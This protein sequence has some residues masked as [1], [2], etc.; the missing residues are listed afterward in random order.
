MG[1]DCS[2]NAWHGAYS[3]FHRWRCEI[4]KAAGYPALELMEGFF[5]S[6][7]WVPSYLKHKELYPHVRMI[8]D[9]SLPLSWDL[10]PDDPLKELLCH[11]DCDGDIQ[12]E[13]CS[14]IADRLQEV[15]KN[16]PNDN[17]GGHIGFIKDKTSVF[18][19]GL[20]LAAKY[21]EPL[22]FH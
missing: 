9:G 18:I 5:D 22:D 13:D 12:P 2:H 4:A 3:A 6:S 8:E 10:F 14:K 7:R 20:R 19:D 21:N 16:L 17:L 15:I 1:L 11:S